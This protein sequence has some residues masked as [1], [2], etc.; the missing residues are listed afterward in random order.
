MRLIKIIGLVIFDFIISM[1]LV[2]IVFRGFSFLVGW[3]FKLTGKSSEAINIILT[4]EYSYD[5][6]FILFWYL[7]ITEDFLPSFK[8]IKYYSKG[9]LRK[10]ISQVHN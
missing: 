9:L 4:S 5:I 2:F 8:G 6:M 7:L 10:I 1:V 3:H